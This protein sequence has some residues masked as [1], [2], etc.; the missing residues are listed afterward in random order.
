MTS[1]P[2]TPVQSSQIHAIGHDPA[3]NTMAIQFKSGKAPVYHYANVDAEE[4]AKFS[5]AESIGSYFYKHI[6]PNAEK[7]PFTRI[8]EPAEQK[9]QET[10][11][12]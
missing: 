6:K 2:L 9:D 8:E 4:F 12:A 10:G 11:A 1:I 3:S 5:G 7:F